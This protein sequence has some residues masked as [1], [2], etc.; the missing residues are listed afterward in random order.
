MTKRKLIRLQY[1]IRCTFVV[2]SYRFLISQTSIKSRRISA[3]ALFVAKNQFCS[4]QEPGLHVQGEQRVPSGRDEEE[5]VP[6]LQVH[7][8]HQSGNEEGR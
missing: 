7:Q 5:P 8:V 2:D 1:C 6:E 3:Q 4:S